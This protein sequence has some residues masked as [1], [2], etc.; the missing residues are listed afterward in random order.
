MSGE[1]RVAGGT[2]D[3]G[4]PAAASSPCPRPPLTLLAYFGTVVSV[5]V[6][7]AVYG[8][9]TAAAVSGAVVFAVLAFGVLRGVLS[10]WVL[11]VVVHLGSAAVLIARGDWWPVSFNAVLVGL[12]VARPT[13]DYVGCRRGPQ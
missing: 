2:D 1:T 10:A 11:L 8:R 5:L 12:L 13:R 7:D 6:V 9:L 3:R 4:Q